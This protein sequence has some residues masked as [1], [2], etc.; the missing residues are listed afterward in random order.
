MSLKTGNGIKRDNRRTKNKRTA[1]HVRARNSARRPANKNVGNRRIRQRRNTQKSITKITLNSWRLVLAILVFSVFS[2]ALIKSNNF[3]QLKSGLEGHLADLLVNSG[4]GIEKIEITGQNQ[5]SDDAIL[6]ALDIGE[7][8]ATLTFDTGAAQRRLENHPWV[9][10]A[11]VMRLL[12]SALKVDI[13]ETSPELIWQKN[14]RLYLVDG[15]GDVIAETKDLLDGLPL[16]VG[17]GANKDAKNLLSELQ[18]IPELEKN[19]KAALRIS[20]RRWT[21]VL[22]NGTQLWLPERHYGIALRDLI[23]QRKYLDI[24]SHNWGA[25]DLRV[26]DRIV[27]RRSMALA[28]AHRTQSAPSMPELDRDALL[29]K[30]NQG[31]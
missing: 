2:Y 20:K 8:R 14:N 23:Q 5:V 26:S 30:L 18:A 4:F 15:N 22:Q 27:V 29:S 10:S 16:L 24:F 11:T 19:L 31:I 12:P 28:A 21:L 13:R 7:K 9:E 1:A 6:R 3:D 25:I 17:T